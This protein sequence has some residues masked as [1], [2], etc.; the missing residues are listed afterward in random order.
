MKRGVAELPLH[1]G[2]VPPWLASRMKKLARLVVMLVVE[3]HGPR[4]FLER[5]ADPVWFQALSNIIG[6]DWDSS[7]STTVTTGV[8]KEVLS[9][10]DVGVYMAG[11][12]GSRS[13]QTPD[14]LRRISELK[15]LDSEKLVEISY[16]VAKVDNAALQD[17]YS[18]YHHAF[19]VAEDGSWAVV[20]QGMNG[21]RK[22]ARRYH[23]FAERPEIRLSSPHKGISGIKKKVVLNTV[24]KGIDQYRK[25]LVD[26]A[27]E[28]PSRVCSEVKAILSL[29]KGYRPLA[30][31]TPYSRDEV[32]RRVRRYLAVGRVGVD[33]RGLIAAA[34]YRPKSYGELLKIRGIGPSTL[35]ALSLVAELVYEVEPSW[36]DPVSHPPDPFK[37]AYAVGGKDGVP[38]P[39]DR[40]MYDEIVEMLEYLVERTRDRW[41]LRRLSEYTKNWTPP[42]DEKIPT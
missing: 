29:A 1:G 37:F 38:F 11:G 4:G 20:Q 19:F 14:E 33:K 18:L 27:Q 5:M 17:G 35:R 2:H 16:L 25:T 8:L 23:W 34:E 12:K 40:R 42:P 26:V 24:D 39:I 31:Y 32:V 6:M 21:R 10:E 22:L 13:R 28:G 7:G 36:R 9:K 3:E 30:F 41:L 15:G